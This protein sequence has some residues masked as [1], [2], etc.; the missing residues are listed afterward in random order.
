MIVDFVKKKNL[1]IQIFCEKKKKKKKKKL[2]YKHYVQ[3]IVYR[4]AK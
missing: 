2:K 1:T 4:I 3:G